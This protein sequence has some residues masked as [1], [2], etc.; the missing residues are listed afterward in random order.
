MDLFCEHLDC[1]TGFFAAVLSV[2]DFV[3]G[4]WSAH[5]SLDPRYVV[6]AT[7]FALVLCVIPQIWRI[8]RQAA[9]IVHEAGHAL[10]AAAVGRRI[11]GIKL[12]TDTSGVMVSRGKP[13]GIGML[14]VCLIGYPAPG[15]LAALMAVGV[16]IGYAGAALSLYQALLL[17]A[18]LLCRNVVGI[19][20]CVASLLMTGVLWFFGTAELVTFTAMMLS[21]FY[22]LAAL[23]CLIDV[24]RVHS[25]V[26]D[27]DELTT[28]A[29]Q[30]RQMVT[31]LPSTAKFYVVAMTAVWVVSAAFV[32][33]AV[34]SAIGWI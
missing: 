10:M 24:M 25:A 33:E 17:Y 27:D 5:A 15:L 3:V 20:S 7:V 1:E 19:L 30:A 18:L 31:V 2:W 29:S 28:D 11:M 8:T 9:T 26:P 12:H 14:A 6:I 34:V 13:K 32:I 16:S 4:R 23:R 22:I 21:V